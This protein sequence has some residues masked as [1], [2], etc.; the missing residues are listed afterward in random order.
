[1]DE[2]A[3]DSASRGVMESVTI[4]KQAELTALRRSLSNHKERSAFGGEFDDDDEDFQAAVITQ[5]ARVLDNH[6]RLNEQ[7]DLVQEAHQVILG[8]EQRG[9]GVVDEMAEQG[10]SLLRSR[11]KVLRSAVVVARSI[12]GSQPGPSCIRSGYLVSQHMSACGV[13]VCVWHTCMNERR[14]LR[15]TMTWIQVGPFS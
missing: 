1:M 10:E 3:R 8:V 12:S 4:E 5:R 13:C 2:V 9:L 15:S 6:Q 7:T 11:D 14:W